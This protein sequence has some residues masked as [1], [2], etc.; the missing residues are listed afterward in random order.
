LPRP[1]TLAEIKAD[2]LL[3]GWDLIRLPRL[4]VLPVSEAQWRR[5]EELSEKEG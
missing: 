4:S 5:V 2:K 3:A 1:V